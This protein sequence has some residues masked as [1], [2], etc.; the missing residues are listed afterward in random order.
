[1]IVLVIIAIL[2]AIAVPSYT[3]YV[4]SAR[5]TDGTEH[6]MAMEA[7][8]ERYYQD[9]RTYQSVGSAVPPCTT[10]QPGTQ[11]DYFT[12][13]CLST[14]PSAYTV[15]AQG[16]GTALGFTYTIDD[17]GTRATT[18]LPARW[19]AAC[20]SAWIVKRGQGCGN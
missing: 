14:G 3:D 19:G 10:G 6:L 11:T 18:A 1:M 16:S 15:Q 4:L 9:N 20:A 17:Q 2:A 12:L 7:N 13:S 5:L 8:M